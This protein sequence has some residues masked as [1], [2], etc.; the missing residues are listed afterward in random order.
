MVTIL[1]RGTKM[2]IEC[3]NCG[4]LLQYDYKDI[5]EDTVGMKAKIWV[6]YIM[7]PQCGARVI[8][9]DFRGKYNEI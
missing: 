5:C 4:A 3:Q 7:C 9:E 8:T 1:R 6:R 2:K